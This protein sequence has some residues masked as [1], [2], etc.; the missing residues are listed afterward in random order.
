VFV[1]IELIGYHANEVKEPQRN[2][3]RA[4]ITAAAI[5]VLI[6]VAASLSIAVVVPKSSL[7]LTAGVME[8]IELFM[9][10]YDLDPLTPWFAFLI[11]TGVCAQASTWIIGP[12]RGIKVPA[13]D[14]YIPPFLAKTNSNDAPCGALIVQAIAVSIV[15]LTFLFMPSI[16]SAIWLLIALLVQIYIMMYL[17]LFISAVRLRYS[18]P[19]VI[20]P[21]KIPGGKP[22]MWII[23]GIG[24]ATCFFMFLTGFWPKVA[25]KTSGQVVLYEVFLIAG[26][27]VVCSPAFIFYKL[28]KPGWK[29]AAMDNDR[30]S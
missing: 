19:D 29:K 30:C 8:A 7:S 21:Y 22:G 23:A 13:E 12:P 11:M 20:R 10:S 25:T 28:R 14:G 18:Q 5:I 15:S 9:R 2:F 16:N 17:M 4:V 24:F 27:A 26:I 3:P 6:Y 1:G